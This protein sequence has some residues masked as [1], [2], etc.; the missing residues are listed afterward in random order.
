MLPLQN[1]DV[2]LMVLGNASFASAVHALMDVHERLGRE[3]NPVVMTTAGFRR[4]IASGDRFATRIWKEPKIY[5]T[6]S[7]HEL[8]KLVE[9]RTTD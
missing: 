7:Q 3:V 4:K 5:V 9:D 8:E 1:S 2:D 6:G